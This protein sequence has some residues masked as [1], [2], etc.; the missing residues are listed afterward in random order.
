[1]RKLY[2]LVDKYEGFDVIKESNSMK[3][4]K[5]YANYYDADVVDGEC[6]LYCY[7]L[8][9]NSLYLMIKNWSY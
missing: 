4:I 8:S 2:R 6:D 3:E 1:M 7:E 9:N 5:S